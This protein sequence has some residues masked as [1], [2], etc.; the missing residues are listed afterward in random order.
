MSTVIMSACWP[1][2]SMS[3]SQKAVL[4]SL[5]DQANDDGVCWPSVARIAVR[6]CLSERAVQGAIRWL[7]EAKILSINDRYGRSNLYE[8]T[9]AAYAPPQMLRGAANAPTPADAAPTPAAPAPAPA[10]AAP[11]TIINHQLT[12]KEP[13]V[14]GATAKKPKS[15]RATIL[16]N[17]FMPDDTAEKLASDFGL[18]LD[19]Q[20]AAFSDHHSAKGTTF[21]DWQAA[22]R[23][24]LRNASK[25]AARS[26][27]GQRMVAPNKQEALE[28]RNRTVGEQWEA[29]MR[30]QMQG[31]RA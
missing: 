8:I 5:A 20:Q 31:G 9:P 26:G 6:T 29:Q 30:A 2:G 25:F 23:T 7:V 11:I 4:I 28:A 13:S 3:P 16:P 19:E 17:D 14:I 15:A 22:F 24:W 1:L 27:G 18:S 10:D 21:I 12:K